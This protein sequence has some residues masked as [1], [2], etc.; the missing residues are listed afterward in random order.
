MRAFHALTAPAVVMLC[1]LSYVQTA[2]AARAAD[3]NGSPEI[4]IR[5]EADRSVDFA[6]IGV[7]PIRQ[8]DYGT[9]R[10]VVLSEADFAAAVAQGISV[11]HAPVDYRLTLGEQSFDPKT[12]SPV[13][14]AELA[15]TAGD[16]AALRLIQVYG[17]SQSAWL[18]AIDAAGAEIV[19]Y[20]HP[21]TYVVWADATSMDRL[22]GEPWL[23]WGGNFEPAYSMLPRYR[24]LTGQSIEARLLIIAHADQNEI[25]NQIT[26]IGGKLTQVEPLNAS[27]NAAR[28]LLDGDKFDDVARIPGVY[29]VKTVPLDGGIRGEMS[30]LVN[31]NSL[32]GMNRAT[33]D[34]PTW[35]NSVGL[36]G[37][38]VIIANVDGGCQQSHT[39]LAGRILACT[40]TTCSGS[41]VAVSHGTHTAGIMAGDAS[42]GTTDAFGFLRGLGVAPGANLVI[43]FYFPHFF[44][45]N[46]MLLLMQDSY[47]N[48]ALLSGN[49]WGPAGSPLGYDDDTMQVDIGVRDVDAGMP[50]DQSLTYVLS[51]MNGYGSNGSGD[52]TQGTPDEGKN[53]LGV[54]STTMQNSDGSQ[55][56]SINDVS[57]NSAHG[58]CL[59]GRKLPLIV[60]PG[61]RVDS[62]V[63]TNTHSVASYCGT[64]MASPQVSGGIAMFA[65][66]YR[67][68]PTYT[69]DPSPALVKAA[70]LAVAD[71]LEGNLDAEGDP[72]G[73]P[74]DS[75]QGYGRFNLEALV[76]PQDAVLYFD[77]QVT[78][79]DTGD[80]WS[81]DV[82][83]IDPNHAMRIMLAWTDAPG[84][85]LGGS[86]PAWNNDLDLVVEDG[87]NTYRGNI[88]AAG[89]YSVAGGVADSQ[90][91][92]EAV[93]LAPTVSDLIT[94]RVSASN[95]NS[96]GLPNIGDGS[97][98]DFAIVC[99]NCAIA[100]TEPECATILGDLNANG[101]ID[102]AD[103]GG[104]A[105]CYANGDPLAAGCP[106]ADMNESSF[107]EQAD[108]DALV[109]C[110]LGNGCP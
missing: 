33:G 74:F 97:D 5:M 107:F 96:D 21:Y 18:D 17:P 82:A 32:D 49:S 66:Y 81:I 72:M 95:I 64:S 102:G 104:F 52:G 3:S 76:A 16:A 103:I 63:P 41:G 23:R 44:S 71:S 13:I 7:T 69:T 106:C 12:Q 105:S 19:Q 47:A 8:I 84:H 77:Q 62:T 57:S 6:S 27:F 10:W 67:L 15:S 39:D 99:Y 86:T 80:E 92:T 34:Y 98:Q 30:S 40:G 108:I 31:I 45:A 29:S 26:A 78:F 90:N 22:A 59:D 101:I 11:S 2:S 53:L 75:R 24:G 46:G 68:L 56:L 43:Q 20:I 9:F 1:S 58:P 37:T 38:G 100:S 65:E 73:P 54:G 79:D 4:G 87:P 48:G 35:L 42:T 93:F 109:S 85:G 14:P 50:G 91:N 55:N 36:D 88:I 70:V 28:L 110:L 89:G 83:P 61:C 60:A 25:E 51:I 94:I